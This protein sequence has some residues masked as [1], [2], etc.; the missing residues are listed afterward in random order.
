MATTTKPQPKTKTSTSTK[1]TAKA[2]KANPAGPLVELSVSL[3]D[4]DPQNQ[5]RPVD[6][7]F[8]D[9]VRTFGVIQPIIVVAHPE[10]A[11]RFMLVAGER[12]W[13]A[14]KQAG[15]VSVPAV[16]R[17]YDVEERIQA[18][19]VENLSRS[20][21]NPV[22]EARQLLRL[23]TLG[24]TQARLAKDLSRSKPWVSARLKL[25]ELPEA[26]LALVEQGTWGVED[27]VAATAL[28]DHPEHLEE[29]VTM[30]PR[31]VSWSVAAMLKDIVFE[32]AA[33]VLIEETV[34]G[35]GTV[36]E[37][38]EAHDKLDEL[39]IAEADHSGEECHGVLIGARNVRDNDDNY[40]RTPVAIGVCTDARR[41]N[42]SGKSDV[43]K[44]PKLKTTRTPAEQALVDAKKEA[45]ADRWAA[46]QTFVQSKLAKSTVVDLVAWTVID[47]ARSDDARKTCRL[48]DIEPDTSRGYTDHQSA[49][50]A[51]A[52]ER[53]INQ[54]RAAVT[55][56]V[57]HHEAGFSSGQ[58][59]YAAKAKR[60]VAVM[61]GQGWKPTKYD[62]DRIKTNKLATK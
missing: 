46:I 29:L 11:D 19:A 51:W 22:Q 48:L 12:R 55:I 1:S 45:D 36:I 39:G 62:R 5:S 31:N 54:L 30:N 53:P 2:T 41:H 20:D 6:A 33:A 47:T 37:V 60:F 27:A 21:L 24:H 13:T 50:V 10:E 43:K 44:P 38:T 14:A 7:K 52:N 25:I 8:V 3:I 18:Q 49:L 61:T 9:S 16:V 26:A 23:S 40:V 15:L 4:P 17:V 58:Q 34:A 42:K 35:G 56:A 28:L 59:F 32:E 57:I